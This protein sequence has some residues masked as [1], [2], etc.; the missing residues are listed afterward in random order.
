M[1]MPYHSKPSKKPLSHFVH[2]NAKFCGTTNKWV[3]VIAG[4]A[5]TLLF[6]YYLTLVFFSELIESLTYE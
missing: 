4:S 5:F 1:Q 2:S 6:F 3:D